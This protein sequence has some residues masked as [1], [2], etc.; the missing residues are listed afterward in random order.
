MRSGSAG[1]ARGCFQGLPSASG[2]QSYF[3]ACSGFLILC[4]QNRQCH[5]MRFR[6]PQ[7]TRQCGSAST[8]WV[9]TMQSVLCP[10]LH[11]L[12]RKQIPSLLLSR[13]LLP[14]LGE[15]TS[16][17]GNKWFLKTAHWGLPLSTVVYH[18]GGKYLREAGESKD[19][20]RGDSDDDQKQGKELSVT[21]S[22][23]REV[24]YIYKW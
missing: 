20:V 5:Q 8:G 7:E 15:N 21:I 4:L 1:R 23:K 3:R 24:S 2:D 6:L 11:V 17:W 22:Q 13:A 12:C 16:I 18:G 14:S 19:G 10:D 9:T